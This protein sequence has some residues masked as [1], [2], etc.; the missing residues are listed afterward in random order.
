MKITLGEKVLTDMEGKD[1]KDY[2]GGPATT[3]RTTI[4]RLLGNAESDDPVRLFDLGAQILHSNKVPMD[5][6]E[7]DFNLVKSTLKEA[8]SPVVVKAQCLKAWGEWKDDS[9]KDK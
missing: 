7:S 2:V 5:I 8:K 6:S 4:A 9:K 3:V 1:L